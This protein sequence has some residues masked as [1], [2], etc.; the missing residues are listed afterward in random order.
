MSRRD[1]HRRAAE[2]ASLRARERGDHAEAQRLWQVWRG[3]LLRGRD[4]F[5]RWQRLWRTDP[6][7]ARRIVAMER[8]A[9]D[10][11]RKGGRR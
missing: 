1:R 11:Q 2:R 7:K 3:L 4:R 5:V 9:E 8:E 6:A 10:M